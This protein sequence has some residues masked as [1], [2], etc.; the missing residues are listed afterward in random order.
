MLWAAGNNRG[1]LRRVRITAVAQGARPGELVYALDTDQVGGLFVY[2]PT[3]KSERR[4][5]HRNEFRA[6]DLCRRPSGETI[7]LSMPHEDGSA[8]IATMELSGR[9]VREVT[10]GDSLDEAPSWAPG[11]GRQVVFQSAGIGRNTMGARVALSSY[12]IQRIDLDSEKFETLLEDEQTD[13]LLPRM[14]ED[15]SLYFIRRPYKPEG[16]V[17]VSPWKVA[18]DIVLFPYRLLLAIV[19]FLNF[20]S[21]MFA[22]KP[23]MTSGGPPKEGPDRRHLL[24]WGK[25]ID[26]E[27]A[28]RESAK[29]GAA[30][31]LVPASW[32]LVRRD[33][34][35]EE[36]VLAR[37][38]LSFDLCSDG[39]VV[40]TNGT[41][42]VLRSADGGTQTI[43]EDKVIEQVRVVG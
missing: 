33:A 17:D 3:D 28:L 23:L 24:L 43:G 6:R 32:E 20:F 31:S 35:G 38:V 30:G 1:D 13:Y 26:T 42:I 39:G 27:K 21:M 19:H 7:A 22:K 15:G 14:G 29:A 9:G 5:F 41:S 2:D 36:Q 12:A 37:G 8:N 25:W 16:H 11:E 4:L 34:G 18:L 10:E 40:Y